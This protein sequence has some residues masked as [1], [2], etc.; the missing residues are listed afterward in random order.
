LDQTREWDFDAFQREHVTIWM[1]T[2]PDFA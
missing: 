2:S 1:Q